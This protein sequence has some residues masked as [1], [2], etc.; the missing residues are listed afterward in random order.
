MKILIDCSSLQV[1][2]GIQVALSFLYDL[3]A[4]KSSENF[5][6]LMSPQLSAVLGKADFSKQFTFFELEKSYYANF[7]KRGKAIK[8]I[9]KTVHPDVIFTV[10]GPSY[11][12]SDFPKVV[13][14]AIPHYIYKDSPFFD[15]LSYRDKMRLYLMQTFQ[16]K[17]FKRADKLIFETEDARQKFCELHK[18]DIK[19]TFVVANR[20]NQI[21]LNSD[22]WKNKTFH[23]NTPNAIL[24]L[25]ANYKHKNL[26]IIPE[27]I[28]SM[29]MK[30]LNDFKFVISLSKEELNF[31][32]ELDMHIEYLGKLPLEVLPS[33]FK[34]VDLLF[35]PTLLECFSTTYLEAMF[36]N[37]PIVTTDLSFAEDV[38][39]NAA[40]YYDPLS[41]ENAAEKIKNVLY[42]KKLKSSLVKN[43]MENLKRFGTSLDRT[44]KYLEIIRE[45]AEI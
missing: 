31:A 13:G 37:V 14:F 40:L 27:V 32:P 33:L 38:C 15:L 19:D 12:K 34:S 4:M 23:F 17:L 2:G 5:I 6:I 1:G 35:M 22:L 20:L 44:N 21:F 24:C 8:K 28:N 45:T 3:K 30:G 18:Y 25:S 39:S 26:A 16:I 7:L 42:S 36:M 41:P 9:E 10:F 29:K 11:H 43:G